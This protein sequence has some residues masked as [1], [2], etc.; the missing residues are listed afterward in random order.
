[1]SM[2]QNASNNSDSTFASFINSIENVGSASFSNEGERRQALQAAQALLVRLESPWDTAMRLNMSQP[3]VGAA[4]RIFKD[5]KVFERWHEQGNEPLTSAQLAGIIEEKCDPTLL[6]RLLRL[7]AANHLVEEVSVGTFR[8]SQFGTAITAPLFDGLFKSYYEL[9]LPIYLNLPKFLASTSY[10]NPQDPEQSPFQFAHDWRGSL[11]TYYQAHP[12]KQ[13]EFNLIQQSIASLQ[14]A[15][16]DIFPTSSFLDSDPATPLLVDVGGSAGH[17]IL[18]FTEL[19]PELASRLYLEDFESVVDA[20]Q[21]PNGVN[22]VAYDFFTPQP[23]KGARAYYMHSIL[24]DWS[25]EPARKILQMQKD[26][27]TPEYSSLLLHDH[28]DVEGPANPQATAFDIQMMA[29]VAGR[30]RT[31]KDWRDLLESVGLA[32]VKIWTIPSAPQSIIEA[33]L[34]T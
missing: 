4:L 15:W 7:L 30:E 16:T 18:K 24:H 1:M 33:K 3:A 10:K 17:D 9:I 23:V 25:D 27:M 21:M 13:A 2:S 6:Y 28:I 11:W 12:E 8:P 26:A 31:E 20:A 29:M 22:K 32:I 19:R 5:L 34:L 14:P